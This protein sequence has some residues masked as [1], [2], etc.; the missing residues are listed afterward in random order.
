MSTGLPISRL[1]NIG[2][3]ITAAG[4]SYANLNSLLIVGD[5]AVIDTV[6]RIRS[7]STL[8]GVATDFGTSAAEYNAAA[9]F[10]N[11]AP[12][13][14]QLY[15]GRW[16][17]TATA[18]QLAGGQIA[19]S[20]QAAALATLAGVA[21]G[22]FKIAVNGGAVTN[23]PGIVLTGVASL[24]AAA[25]LISAALTTASLAVGCVWTGTQFNFTSTTTGATSNV[26][27]L[28]SPTAGTDISAMLLGTSTG[29]GYLVAGQT[30]ETP[31][32]AIVA[33][34]S[35]AA[36]WYGLAW[37]CATFPANTDYVAV[38]GY[39]ETASNP[40]LHGVT[41]SE[42][43]ALS[44]VATT[45]IGYLL[46]QLGYKRT[47]ATYSSQS[48]FAASGIFGDLL[49][50]NLLGSNTLP[51]VMWKSITGMVA[52]SLNSSQATALDTKRYNYFAAFNNGASVVVNGTCA[53]NAYIDEI[54]G[55]DWL[56]NQIQTD[57]FNLL[58]SVPKIPQT[59]AGMTQI[60]N[61]LEASLIKGVTNGLIG[62]NLIWQ[63]AGFGALT[64]GQ[65]I[66][67]GFY[68]YIPKLAN[69]SS[70][71]RALR[72]TP[73]IQVAVKLAGAVDYVNVTLTINR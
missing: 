14:T 52:E 19:T 3:S 35:N 68:V 49:T 65:V 6:Q 55:V 60:Q 61:T 53:G 69:Q 32:A 71:S 16:A 40:H 31:L 30:L 41:S 22:G 39:L 8:A 9:M 5:S 64:A 2:W 17:R 63:A 1:I 54:F 36:S 57:Q 46:Q 73:P 48:A 67:R 18:G 27:F 56:A 42:P 72:V 12:T 29:G 13:P 38:S 70:A 10:F 21:S 50:T 20:A 59:D 4:A 43:A 66:P 23:V 62:K 11:Q 15:I 24:S 28:T 26:S 7:Y 51:T 25:A 58:V 45:D 34:D 37:G 47:F 33:L 44:S